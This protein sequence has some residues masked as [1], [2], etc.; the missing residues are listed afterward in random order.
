MD[1][2]DNMVV[3]YEDNCRNFVAVVAPVGWDIH[4]KV[5]AEAGRGP[6]PHQDIQ[7]AVVHNQVL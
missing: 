4:C 5:Q 2:A 6:C 3:G 1:I 7:V